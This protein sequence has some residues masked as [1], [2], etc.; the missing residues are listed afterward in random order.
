MRELLSGSPGTRL[1][2]VWLEREGRRLSTL[3]L[4]SDRFTLLTGSS[5]IDWLQALNQVA[6]AARVVVTVMPIGAPNTLRDPAGDWLR[7]SGIEATGVLLVR[8]D[9]IVAWRARTADA[10]TYG[11]L[12]HVFRQVLG[13]SSS[14]P[15]SDTV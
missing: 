7:A 5:G 1:P 2:H 6:E 4:V 8:P 14:R 10:E 12:S 15:A 3:D 13:R 9:G 11:R